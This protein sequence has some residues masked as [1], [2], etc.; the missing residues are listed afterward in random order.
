VTGIKEVHDV[1]RIDLEVVQHRL[2]VGYR[3]AAA[4]KTLQLQR[5]GR[6][7]RDR[8]RPRLG[9]IEII[10]GPDVGVQGVA[11]N[12]EMQI[13]G[14]RG[15]RKTRD[16]NQ[17]QRQPITCGFKHGSNLPGDR[18]QNLYRANRNAMLDMPEILLRIAPCPAT[19][20]SFSRC[21]PD[22]KISGRTIGTEHRRGDASKHEEGG[23]GR[24]HRIL[25][26]RHPEQFR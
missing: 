1:V 24:G 2:R 25:E 10:N 3:E 11:Q 9:D 26:R 5:Q 20:D 17:Q 14:N 21:F 16:T 19:G 13:G 22:V 18:H 12:Q 4:G 8:L 23:D 15:T 7:G 6:V